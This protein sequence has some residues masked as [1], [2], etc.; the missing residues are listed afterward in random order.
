MKIMQTILATSLFA[1]T[2]ALAADLDG[3][4][5]RTIDDKTGQAK[6]IVQFK[7]QANG[8]YNGTIVKLL[9]NAERTCS[10]CGGVLKNK[11][12]EGLTIVHGLKANGGN[13]Y[14]NGQILDPKDGRTYSFKATESADGKKLEGRGYIGVSMLGRSQT[15]LRAN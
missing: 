5:W 14:V 11:P 13:S 7:K 12:V 10:A 2:F 4:Q 6:A 8:T 3:T 15:W 9:G 1:S